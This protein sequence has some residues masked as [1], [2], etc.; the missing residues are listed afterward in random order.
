ML[1]NKRN[2][3]FSPLQ[4]NRTKEIKA[5]ELICSYSLLNN[6]YPS[7]LLVHLLRD[8]SDSSHSRLLSEAARMYCLLPKSIMPL[9]NL[10]LSRFALM[11]ESDST[12]CE[13]FGS[14]A[15]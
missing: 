12:A 6:G 4:K 11:S 5:A 15:V 3:V 9:V 13:H 7:D 2:Q 10:H 1:A 8:R 14:E